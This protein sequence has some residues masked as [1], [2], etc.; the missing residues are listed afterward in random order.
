MENRKQGVQKIVTVTV[1]VIGGVEMSVEHSR[2]WMFVTSNS[3]AA[4]GNGLYHVTISVSDM[5]SEMCEFIHS[6]FKL[7]PL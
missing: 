1:V 3:P 7:V 2:V 6:A 4:D 5:D